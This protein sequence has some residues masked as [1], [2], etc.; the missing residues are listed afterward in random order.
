MEVDDARMTGTEYVINQLGLALAAAEQRIVQLEAD[1]AAL[2]AA[3]A[4]ERRN[5]S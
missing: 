3:M 5:E 4:D 1:L 2:R